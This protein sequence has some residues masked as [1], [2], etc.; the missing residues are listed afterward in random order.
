MTDLCVI[1]SGIGGALVAYEAAR[2]GRSVVVLETGRRFEEADPERYDLARLELYPW[3][4]EEEGRDAFE[5]DTELRVR[6]N[7]SR[8][9][10]VGGTTLHWNAYTPR[11]QPG[12]FEMRSRHGIADDWPLSY[13]ELEPY[14]V[15]AEQELGVS[16]GDAPGGPPRS[17][18]YPN[19]AHEYSFSDREFFFPA[20]EAAGLRLGPNPMA[21]NSRPYDGRSTCL[22]YAT[23]APMC[24]T[25]AKYTA[26]VHLRKAEE[27]G[28]VE[29]RSE[30]HVRRLRLAGSRRV[31]RVEYV[32]GAGAEQ[33]LEARTFVI[34]AG[35]VETPRLLLLSAA[36]GAHAH[37]LGNA[38]GLVGR[39]LM[40]HVT[41][42]VRATMPERVG[43]HRLGYGTAVSWDYYD[44]STLP[45]V[46]N[47]VLFPA[48]LQGPSPAEIARTSG[49]WGA[50]LKRHVRETYGH[51][52]K[53]VAEG[54]ML[55]YTEN[56]V[57]L[58]SATR[59][60]YGDP[61][62]RLVVGFRDFEHRTIARGHE[63]GR[64][65]ME[66]AGAREMWTDSNPFVPHFMGTTCMGRDPARSV[67]DGYGRVHDLDNLY[68]A[69]SSLFPTSA[70]SH[71]TTTIAAMAIRTGEHIA[72]AL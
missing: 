52:L 28:R 57:E 48:D 31:G 44:D 46:G 55:P 10:A 51:N 18:P 53:I 35:G 23:C 62:P 1:G 36:E 50:E 19:P 4:W 34:S 13:A 7:A 15:R 45:D 66:L 37:G 58:S 25:R 40:F 61:I 22:G 43:G 16:G 54:E 8:I 21:V 63:I 29:I 65:V 11:L 42:A 2:A 49:L 70:A 17:A 6:V 26:M 64:R 20:F 67:C 9:K 59:D 69:S 12:D 41:A 38:S 5:L 30:S 3:A 14:Y 56:R 47:L 39:R 60:R 71:P 24:P 72:S 33:T 68:I 27:T 32:D